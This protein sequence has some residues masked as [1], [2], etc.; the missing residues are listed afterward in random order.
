MLMH[1]I[2]RIADPAQPQQGAHAQPCQPPRQHGRKDRDQYHSR[3]QQVRRVGKQNR[4]QHR[5]E[6]G[7]LCA[8]A[9]LAR[10][11]AEIEHADDEERPLGDR[12][13]V[14]QHHQHCDPLRQ[15]GPKGHHALARQP[16]QQ[17]RLQPSLSPHRPERE[18]ADVE[19]DLDRQRP[20]GAIHRRQ[21]YEA[22]EHRDIGEDRERRDLQGSHVPGIFRTQR[23]R[24]RA[25][26][27][28]EQPGH[29]VHHE[30]RCAFRPVE[31]EEDRKSGDGEEQQHPVIAANETER[32]MRASGKQFVKARAVMEQHHRQSAKATQRVQFLQ[33]RPLP[34]HSRRYTRLHRRVE[35]L[36][37]E[38]QGMGVILPEIA[39][40]LPAQSLRL[41]QCAEAAFGEQQPTGKDMRLNEVDAVG[42]AIEQR[43]VDADILDRSPAAGFQQAVDRG[44]IVRPVALADRLHHLD[45]CDR[46]IDASGIAIVGQM[47]RGPIGKARIGQS[48]LRMIALLGG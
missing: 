16:R 29:A 7:R 25:P 1:E 14:E 43:V 24:H 18:H 3:H 5:D 11:D 20:V 45:A 13:K 4:Q 44:E 10:P 41:R 2:Q 21:E 40:V 27:S 23:Q 17:D 38:P 32:H 30:I 42:V 15:S 35:P 12:M 6:I 34:F 31:R 9:P 46:V 26:I 28:G 48:R 8:H 37:P 36:P 19:A 22:F 39:L 33:P 47:H